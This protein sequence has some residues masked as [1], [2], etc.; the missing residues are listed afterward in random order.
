MNPHFQVEPLLCPLKRKSVLVCRYLRK[1]Y[2]DAV[3][4]KELSLLFSIRPDVLSREFKKRYGVGPLTFV[5]TLRV[6]EARQ[7]L[8]QRS[9]TIKEICYRVGFSNPQAFC[10]VFKRLTRLSPHAYREYTPASSQV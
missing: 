6:E 2:H 3:S 8:C 4:L 5:R 1:N 7:L 9:F 10:K